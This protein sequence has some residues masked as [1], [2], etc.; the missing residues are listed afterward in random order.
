MRRFHRVRSAEGEARRFCPS[1]DSAGRIMAGRRMA[2]VDDR[3]LIEGTLNRVQDF[4]GL[5]L[6]A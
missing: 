5:K 4:R 2:G 3:M 6:V 1:R